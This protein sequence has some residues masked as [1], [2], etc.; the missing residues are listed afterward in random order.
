M[1]LPL[2]QLRQQAKKRNNQTNNSVEVC[3]KRHNIYMIRSP[4]Q[5]YTGLYASTQ[6]HMAL[7][8]AMHLLHCSNCTATMLLQQFYCNSCTATIAMNNALHVYGISVAHTKATKY[9]GA[10]SLDMLSPFSISMACKCHL[11]ILALNCN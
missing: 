6:L 1:G 7:H 5:K 4:L 8:F 2:G 11:V 9:V 3:R 10:Q